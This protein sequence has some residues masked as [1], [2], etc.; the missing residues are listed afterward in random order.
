M[1]HLS[2][3]VSIVGS[4]LAIAVSWG[5]KSAQMEE[6]RRELI[7]MDKR[8]SDAAT[9]ESCLMKHAFVNEKFEDLKKSIEELKSIC[10]AISEQIRDKE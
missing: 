9:K 5:I 4:L 7:A 8:I 3:I 10:K 2:L 6:F 1:E